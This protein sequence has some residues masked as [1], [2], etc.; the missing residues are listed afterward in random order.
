MRLRRDFAPSC[1]NAVRWDRA[2]D[3][4]RSPRVEKFWATFMF[5]VIRTAA[6]T[7]TTKSRRRQ[8]H[9]R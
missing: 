6:A 2:K 8:P 5:Y 7:T 4:P 9:Q 3:A 1:N